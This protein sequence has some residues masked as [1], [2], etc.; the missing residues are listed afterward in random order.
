MSFNV[1]SQFEQEVLRQMSLAIKREYVKHYPIDQSIIDLIAN[2]ITNRFLSTRNA[3]RVQLE[4]FVDRLL[5]SL[6]DMIRHYSQVPSYS[7]VERK[8][9]EIIPRVVDRILYLRSNSITS[10]PGEINAMIVDRLPLKDLFN[11]V[12]Y[13]EPG[14]LYDEAKRLTTI[15]LRAGIL[16]EKSIFALRELVAEFPFLKP[17]AITSLKSRI[18]S[19]SV[20]DLPNIQ[21]TSNLVANNSAPLSYYLATYTSIDFQQYMYDCLIHC[22][23]SEDDLFNTEL[24][25]RDGVNFLELL[26]DTNNTAMSYWHWLSLNP[27]L[28]VDFLLRTRDRF[29]WTLIGIMNNI[30]FNAE[31]AERLYDEIDEARIQALINMDIDF[32]ETLLDFIQHH[33]T[34]D[35]LN[36]HP[37]WR[38]NDFYYS[39][40]DLDNNELDADGTEYFDRKFVEN[41]N[42][43]EKFIADNFDKLIPYQILGMNPS[44]SLDFI[45]SHPSSDWSWLDILNNINISPNDLE[46]HPDILIKHPELRLITSSRWLTRDYLLNHP[47]LFRIGGIYANPIFN[48]DDFD[49]LIVDQFVDF[50]NYVFNPNLSNKDLIDSSIDQDNNFEI[51]RR[52]GNTKLSMARLNYHNNLTWDPKFIKLIEDEIIFLR[53]YF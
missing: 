18:R 34:I 26:D 53:T 27:N 12:Q 8:I 33:M 41:P 50:S 6:I 40:E 43:T 37:E 30:N 45:I 46:R 15:K 5:F 49:E 52:F 11:I 28:S 22:A 14:H 48:L 4:R 25:W 9:R 42:I 17:W 13:Q 36:R 32:R 19:N 23:L 16:K 44:V 1:G 31:Y 3:D 35:F 10:L 47:E 21:L 7:F 51:T 2:S 24:H 39:E 20:L 29:P 38:R